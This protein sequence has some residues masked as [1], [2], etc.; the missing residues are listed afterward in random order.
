MNHFSSIPCVDLPIPAQWFLYRN[1]LTGNLSASMRSQ[2]GGHKVL[3]WLSVRG[4][5]ACTQPGHFTYKNRL[6]RQQYLEE[7]FDISVH[8]R[9]QYETSRKIRRLVIE[10]YSVM[11][12]WLPSSR[13]KAV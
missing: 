12:L 10:V 5:V 6:R 4:P 2:Q 9:E 11:R 7:R 1:R 8:D 3:V 13:Y